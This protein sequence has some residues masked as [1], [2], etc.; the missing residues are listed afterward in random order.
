MKEYC[1]QHKIALGLTILL[2]GFII[3]VFFVDIAGIVKIQEVYKPYVTNQ[4]YLASGLLK[5]FTLI[6]TMGLA[7]SYKKDESYVYHIAFNKSLVIFIVGMLGA[8]LARDAWLNAMLVQ[9]KK[10]EIVDMNFKIAKEN[11]LELEK[12]IA[13]LN[14]SK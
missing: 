4:W 8:L 5:F 14:V 9:H 3:L 1:L 12:K 7:F 6:V 13:E 10:D 11:L 2:L